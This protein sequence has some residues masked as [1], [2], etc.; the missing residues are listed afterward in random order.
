LGVRFPPG[1]PTPRSGWRYRAGEITGA[2]QTRVNMDTRAENQPT[3]LDT[4]KLLLA[5]GILIGSIVAYY[6]YANESPLLRLIGVL[7]GFALAVWVAFQ[8]AQ[9]RTLWAFIQGSRVEL[10][11]V[12][13]PSREETVQTT[14]IVFAFGAIMST[15]FWLLDFFLLWAYQFITGQGG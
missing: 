13:W 5:V 9:G 8:S 3:I 1:L 11:K 12:V 15:F 6:Y 14:L 4:V 10:R 7:V 2:R